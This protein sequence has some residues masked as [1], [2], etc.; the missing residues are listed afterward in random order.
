LIALIDPVDR[1]HIASLRPTTDVNPLAYTEYRITR[2]SD[3]QV[4]WIAR[5]GEVRRNAM[6]R[7]VL[8][9]GV[10][11][12]ITEKKNAELRL[13]SSESRLRLA[14]DAGRMAV[15]L[16]HVATDSAETSPDLNVLLGFAPDA[17][18]SMSE[19]R[20]RYYPGERDRLRAIATTALEKGERY[21]ETE[22]RIVW[23]DQSV[24]WLL[25]RAEFLM[26]PD[27]QP[28]QVIGVLLDITGRKMAEEHQQLLLNELN[29]RVKNTLSTVQSLVSQTLRTATSTAQAHEAVESR[30]F[31]LSRVHDVLTQENWESARL[32]EVV[33]RALDPYRSYGEG[34]LTILGHD[35]RISPRI[36]LAL[37]M[38]LQE[39]A[40]N[41]MKYGALSNETG[42]VRIDWSIDNVASPPRLTF[43]WRESGGPEVT[44]PS[45]R[46]FGS[47]MLEKSLAR[48]L[49]GKV[50]LAF[51]R[52]G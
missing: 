42:A 43:E 20:S 31:A 44:P 35:R 27:P 49:D 50:T 30:L 48:E 15:W 6:G 47:R 26:G 14:I 52:A 1:E 25:L 17:R 10:V 40:T 4:R 7:V 24:R 22:Y 8:G 51:D 13:E 28:H 34:R 12:D 46:G 5:R 38:G 9:F 45:L 18:P 36:A 39:L 23:P 16:Y 2:P 41:A 29:H 21:F 33:E 32:A 11:Y 19:I 37:A 3:G